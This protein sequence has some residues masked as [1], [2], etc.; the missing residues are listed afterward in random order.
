[1]RTPLLI[2]HDRDDRQVPVEQATEIAGVWPGSRVI[3]TAGLGHQRP[4]RDP[5]VV[6]T[7]VQHLRQARAADRL[8]GTRTA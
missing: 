3:T 8:P 1:M 2:L 4:L 6:T 5:G 7:V